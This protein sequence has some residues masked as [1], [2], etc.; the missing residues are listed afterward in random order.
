[1]I[2]DINE[3]GDTLFTCPI[4]WS[5]TEKINKL[6][7]AL[8]VDPVMQETY[9]YSNQDCDPE[10]FFL[11]RSLWDKILVAAKTDAFTRFN[12][13]LKHAKEY[14]HLWICNHGWICSHCA[15]GFL[16]PWVTEIGTQGLCQIAA[17]QDG[18]RVLSELI[19][20]SYLRYASWEGAV[21]N[22]VE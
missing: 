10:T 12:M 16:H 7:S 21:N 9:L 15:N 14:E 11:G 5:V 19:M 3:N 2:Y 22:T 1:M 20:F 6:I 8:I 13:M 18:Q 4:A 17:L